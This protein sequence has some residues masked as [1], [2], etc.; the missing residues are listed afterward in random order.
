MS[1]RRKS[2]NESV[3][4]R[5][6]TIADESKKT[7]IVSLWGDLATNTGQELLDIADKSPVVAI[8]SLKVGDFQGVSLSAISKSL[9]LIGRHLYT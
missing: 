3:A 9:V 6:I 2:N 1:I 5:D 8:K 4:K 7:V